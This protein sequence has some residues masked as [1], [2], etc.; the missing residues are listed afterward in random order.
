MHGAA[1]SMVQYFGYSIAFSG[2]TGYTAYKR[3][4]Q[5][6]E[7]AAKQDLERKQLLDEELN[8]GEDEPDED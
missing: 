6:Q 3:Q 1:V 7:Q 8:T 5:A 2:V 4:L